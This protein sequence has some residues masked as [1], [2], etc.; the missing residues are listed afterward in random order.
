MLELDLNIV[1]AYV[2]EAVGSR[3][4]KDGVTPEW[5]HPLRVRRLIEERFEIHDRRTLAVALMHDLIEDT[6]Q[7]GGKIAERFGLAI[8]T[9]VDDQTYRELSRASYPTA[10]ERK[11]AKYEE[12]MSR[13]HRWRMRACLVSLADILDNL[14]LNDGRRDPLA[15]DPYRWFMV[16]CMLPELET[17]MRVLLWRRPFPSDLISGDGQF[18]GKRP[19]LIDSPTERT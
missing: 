9:H 17:R 2:I 6:D 12:K 4:R 18:I 5:A 13:V 8:A 14:F 7:H 16:N 15:R 11:V 10:Q 19:L 1:E 3:L